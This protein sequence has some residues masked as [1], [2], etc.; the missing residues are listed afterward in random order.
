MIGGGLISSRIQKLC[1]LNSLYFAEDTSNRYYTCLGISKRTQIES[2]ALILSIRRSMSARLLRKIGMIYT[3]IPRRPYQKA[4]LPQGEMWSQNIFIDADHAGD[5]A[6]RR[7]H[8]R[9]L[10]FLNKALILWYSKQTNTIDT[11]TLSS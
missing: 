10:I 4:L 3:G 7:S 1:L 9:I 5:R 2:F 6:T 11:S 8:T